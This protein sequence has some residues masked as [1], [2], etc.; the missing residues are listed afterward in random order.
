MFSKKRLLKNRFIDL[1]YICL[2]SPRHTM[3]VYSISKWAFYGICLLILVLPVSRHWKL[4]TGGERTEGTVIEYTMTLQETR[5]GE[6]VLQYASEIHF[7]AGDSTC[8][9][10]GPIDLE[11]TPGRIIRIRFDPEDPSDN[12]LVTFSALYLTYYTVLPIIL[13]ILW[14]AFYLSFNNYSKRFRASRSKDS[15]SSPRHVPG[16]PKKLRTR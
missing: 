14:A 13:L 11:L 12:C 5:V 10:Y 15:P 9:A 8:I 16:E 3:K 7:Q 1:F 6:K 4:L 2:I